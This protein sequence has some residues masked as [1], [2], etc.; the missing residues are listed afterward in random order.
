MGYHP[1]VHRCCCLFL[2]LQQAK[3][4]VDSS[5]L[6][7]RGSYLP[8]AYCVDNSSNNSTASPSLK[9]LFI[10][11]VFTRNPTN[12]FLKSSYDLLRASCI[13][14]PAS[15]RVS[16]PASPT[17]PTQTPTHLPLQAELHLPHPRKAAPAMSL[18][19]SDLVR[20]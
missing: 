6:H 5:L 10:R 14:L 15:S 19:L 17:R 18:S 12:S 4:L 8:P 20:R 7:L 13:T 11:C 16:T 1:T 2:L 9:L 3:P